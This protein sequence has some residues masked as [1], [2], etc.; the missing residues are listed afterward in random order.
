MPLQSLMTAVHE[1]SEVLHVL[2]KHHRDLSR[3]LFEKLIAYAL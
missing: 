3:T 1:V 2:S